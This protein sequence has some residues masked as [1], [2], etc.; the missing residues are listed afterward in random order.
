MFRRR[1]ALATLC[2]GFVVLALTGATQAVA[3]PLTA[4]DG[5]GRQWRQLFETTGLSANDVA[6]VC[7]RDGATACSGSIGATDLTGWVWATAPQVL[8]LM[9]KYEPALLSEAPPSASEQYF[10]SAS[11]FLTDMRWTGYI[12]TYVGYSEWTSGWTASTDDTGLPLFGAVGYGWWPPFGNF[13][14]AADADNAASDRGVWLWRS[15]TADHTPP[16]ITPT[17]TGTAGDNGWYVSDVSVSWTVEDAESAVTSS[18]DPASVTSDSTTTLVCEATSAGG[19]ATESSVV[20]RDV[21]APTVTCAANAPVFEIQ[22]QGASVTASVSDATSGPAASAVLGAAGTGAPGTFSVSITGADRAGN[23]AT[24]QCAYVVT[25]PTCRGL[26]PTRIGT[27][28]NDVINGTSGR[29]V[30][31]ALG[32][33]DTINGLAGDDVICGGDGMDTIDGGDGNDWIDGGA[34]ADDLNGG[35]GDDFIDGGPDLDSIRGGNGKD[36]CT[37][38]EVRMSSC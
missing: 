30:I 9:G 38:G 18:C 10:Y 36:S 3:A 29:D 4:D 12:V 35:N 31:L 19:T 24:E 7:S 14:V 28:Q 34:S 15:S 32:G 2:F 17:V 5:E 27:A 25:V 11:A 21:T 1:A 26:A 13:G 33:A 37:S 16:V 20:Q 22:Q 8:G 6:Q 23:R